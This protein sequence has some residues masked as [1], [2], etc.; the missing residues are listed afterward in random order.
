MSRT[1]S[2]GARRTYGVARVCS[3]WE[4]PRSSYYRWAARTCAPPREVV[5]PRPKRG[6]KTALDDDALLALIRGYLEG[7]PFVGEGHRKV[8]AHL[9]VVLGLKTSRTRILRLMREN[10]L[11]SPHRAPACPRKAHDGSITTGAPDLLWGTDGFRV[12]TVEDGWVW[13]FVA[14][15]HFNHEC[16]GHHVAKP[17][18]R[19]EALQPL[20]MAL[21]DLFGST[22]KDAARGLLLRMDHGPQYTSDHFLVARH[23]ILAS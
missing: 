10:A 8:Y 9:K 11:L 12:Q 16:V 5:G 19:F 1:I 23:P 15:D 13:G 4:V 14:V 6:P 17:G 22:G 2:E 20:S 21:H 3:A 7:S 18:T